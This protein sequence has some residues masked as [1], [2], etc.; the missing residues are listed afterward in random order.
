MMITRGR[1]CPIIAL[2]QA[3][4]QR[5]FQNLKWASLFPPHPSN[6]Q[7][8]SEGFEALRAPHLVPWGLSQRSLEGPF[9]VSLFLRGN[10]SNLARQPWP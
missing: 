2:G 8:L 7:T 3:Q 6:S 5:G 9:P 1:C 10:N 4:T